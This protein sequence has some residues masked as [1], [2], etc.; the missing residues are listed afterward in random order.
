MALHSREALLGLLQRLRPS[1]QST[2]GGSLRT[3]IYQQK[4]RCMNIRPTNHQSL[5]RSLHVIATCHL[6]PSNPRHF[7]DSIYS[8]P[9]MILVSSPSQ[10]LKVTTNSI[11]MTVPRDNVVSQQCSLKSYLTAPHSWASHKPFYSQ[12]QKSS[13]ADNLCGHLASSS[14]RHREC[15]HSLPPQRIVPLHCCVPGRNSAPTATAAAVMRTYID[16]NAAGARFGFHPAYAGSRFFY[17]FSFS[18]PL[19]SPYSSCS[20]DSVDTL[21]AAAARGTPGTGT[22]AKSLAAT[23]ATAGAI[24]PAAAAAALPKQLHATIGDEELRGKE[25]IIIVGDVHGERMN[26]SMCE[27]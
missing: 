10:Q 7:T 24:A 1:M 26:A 3:A 14:R 16:C 5:C 20:S 8:D 21:V 22:A 13:P 27:C 9:T 19:S 15:L 23:T 2:R 4:C 11:R 6:P 18:S 17:S 12:G 25:R